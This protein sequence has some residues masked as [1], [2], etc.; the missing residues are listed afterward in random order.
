MPIKLLKDPNPNSEYDNMKVEIILPDDSPLDEVVQACRGFL[1]CIGFPEDCI[2][3][4][5]ADP[6][7]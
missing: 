3:E 6:E 4:Y 5:F 7:E 1:I 2:K